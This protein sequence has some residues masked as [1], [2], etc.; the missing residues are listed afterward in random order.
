MRKKNSSCKKKED[1]L[2]VNIVPPGRDLGSTIRVSPRR[3]SDSKG[4]TKRKSSGKDKNMTAEEVEKFCKTNY[5]DCFREK[6]QKGARMV[7]DP[8]ELVLI[9]EDVAS[10]HRAWAREVPAHHKKKARALIDDLL[11]AGVISEVTKTS[12]FRLGEE[13]KFVGFICGAG[14]EGVYVQPDLEKI[15]ALSNVQPPSPK[16]KSELFGIYSP[17]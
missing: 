3:D 6:L 7:C 16:L 15:S 4:S 17:V 5:A 2:I 8:V 10:H 14:E 1:K 11:Q 12:K 13:V 9:N